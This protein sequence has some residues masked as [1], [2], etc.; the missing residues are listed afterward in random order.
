MPF[1]EYLRQFLQIYVYDIHGLKNA[2]DMHS[3]RTE[4]FT[5]H[6]ISLHII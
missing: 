6:V 3:L 4:F 1:F 5:M 2:K